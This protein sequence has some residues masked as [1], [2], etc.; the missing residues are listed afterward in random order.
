MGNLLHAAATFLA[1]LTSVAWTWVLAALACQLGKI[2]VRSRAWR[3]I[4]AAAYPRTDVRW[5]S[6]FGA[7]A[8]G[9]GV[10]AIVPVRGGDLLKLHLVRRRIDGASYS[11]LTASLFVG[12]I[13]DSILSG[14]LLLWALHEHV[15]PGIDVV[16][17]LPSVPW[18]WPAEHPLGV[19]VASA[20][21][22][23]VAFV[24]GRRAAAGLER[25]GRRVACGFAILRTPSRYLRGVVAWQ[26]VDWALRLATIYFLLRA[27]HITAGLDAGLRVQVTQSL[28]TIVPLT[29]AGLGTE[30]A[31]IVYVLAGLAPYGRLLAL[32]V[33]MK[34]IL[35]GV[36]IAIGVPAI[37]LMLG[38]LRWRRVLDAD[39]ARRARPD[40]PAGHRS[41]PAAP[42]PVGI[43]TRSVG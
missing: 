16:D 40:R 12:T 14:L 15:L 6:V 3:N 43:G 20:L 24:L 7:Y 33:G 37:A 9:A 41:L 36:D 29:P 21:V 10:N 5:R 17:G 11:T 42:S 8:A 39:R 26:L 4:L 27:F 22:L 25:F 28:S 1:D 19:A 13:V 2:V 31:L 23:V 38:T 35:S 34:A 30:Q 18:L 32:G